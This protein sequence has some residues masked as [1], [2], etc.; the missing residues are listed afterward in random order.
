MQG[1]PSR[2]EEILTSRDIVCSL[3]YIRMPIKSKTVRY[4]QLARDNETLTS[5]EGGISLYFDILPV[6]SIR[7]DC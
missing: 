3:E 2:A 1:L 5:R 6:Y 7:T 4:I